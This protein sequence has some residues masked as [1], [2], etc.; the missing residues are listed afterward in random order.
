MTPANSAMA[1]EIGEIPELVARFLSKDD[2]IGAAAARIRAF[3]PRVVIVCGRGSSGH[4]GTYLRYL[5]ETGLGLIT[6]ESTPSVFTIYDTKQDMRGALFIVISQSGQ[7]PDLLRST[8][9]AHEQGALTLAI[10]NDAASPVA[11]AC[12]LVIDIL[13]GP[14]RA[15]AA[16]KTVVLSAIA[17]ALLIGKLAQDHDLLAAAHRLPGRL[18]AALDCDWSSW[19]TTVGDA[20]ASFV[21]GR[22]FALGPAREIAL[23]ITEVLG[24]PSLAFSSAELRHGPRAA[25]KRDTPVL[26][27]RQN[28]GT[29]EANDEL[30]SELGDAGTPVFTTGGSH[31]SL[32]W[33]GNDHPAL[34]PVA[35]LLPAYAAIEGV[36]RARG[37]DPDRPPFLSKVTQTL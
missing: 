13:A 37:L 32:P 12:K 35:M 22:G 27:L 15:V 3:K 11:S 26:V 20:C 30:V 25:I 36:A 9:V 6:S 14:E 28:D 29:A 33:I 21:A 34:D 1:R 18:Y 16:T 19:A 31:K 4:V 2:P 24:A 23:K 8:Q 10:V 5:V 7:S 17:G